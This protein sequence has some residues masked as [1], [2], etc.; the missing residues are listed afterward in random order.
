MMM[1]GGEMGDEGYEKCPVCGD[2]MALD[3]DPAEN[4]VDENTNIVYMLPCGHRA[5]KVCVENW[6]KTAL[7]E[8][9]HE[10]EVEMETTL[11]KRCPQ[12]RAL[13]TATVGPGSLQDLNRIQANPE[14]AA[15][16]TTK[17]RR[18]TQR[19]FF[20]GEQVPLSPY[21][22]FMEETEAGSEGEIAPII[23]TLYGDLR[24]L[25]NGYDMILRVL[26]F[27]YEKTDS[28]R[29]SMTEGVRNRSWSELLESINQFM[30][31]VE[32]FLHELS[33]NNYIRKDQI[34]VG[35]VQEARFSEMIEK[36]LAHY[37][38]HKTDVWVLP[39]ASALLQFCLGGTSEPARGVSEEN[40]ERGR[41][42]TTALYERVDMLFPDAVTAAAQT[43]A[44]G[45]MAACGTCGGRRKGIEDDERPRKKRKR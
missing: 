13:V 41:E 16:Y 39:V 3:A 42:R 12:C 10:Q 44:S 17:E 26:S 29:Q 32:Y 6:W 45:R 40:W 31:L 35:S 9:S 5:H 23:E 4:N 27:V 7:P 8:Q 19:R 34:D 15:R 38:K 28:L 24:V 33:E 2:D 14:L 43:A 22:H 18:S 21:E 30:D 36:S 25:G 37:E 1:A 11:Q 20:H